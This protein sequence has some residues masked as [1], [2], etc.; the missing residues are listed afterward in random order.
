MEKSNT[1]KREKN[2]NC[3]SARNQ[4]RKFTLVALVALVAKKIEQNGRKEQ[5]KRKT[6]I[7]PS[8]EKR[9]GLPPNSPILIIPHL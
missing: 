8:W 2:G 7:C 4:K 1:K 3:P 9:S 6:A 5:K